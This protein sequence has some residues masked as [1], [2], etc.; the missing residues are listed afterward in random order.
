MWCLFSSLKNNSL[1]WNPQI[2][3]EWHISGGINR[4]FSNPM[5]GKKLARENDS[6]IL[7]FTENLR[8]YEKRSGV[9][10]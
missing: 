2:I 5:H 9:D 7:C 10:C 8:L 1:F 4:T 6:F 3:N